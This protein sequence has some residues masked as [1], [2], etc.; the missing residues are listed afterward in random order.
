MQLPRQ[1]Q[2]RSLFFEGQAEIQ[3]KTCMRHVKS[4]EFKMES[5][6]TSSIYM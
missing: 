6:S 5:A 1:A 2:F 3:V 4:Q